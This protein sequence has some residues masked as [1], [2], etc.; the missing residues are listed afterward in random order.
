MYIKQEAIVD[1]YNTVYK[2][3]FRRNVTVQTL[4][5]MIQKILIC[6]GLLYSYRF[7]TFD[8]L[9]EDIII[10]LQLLLEL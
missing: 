5:K 6:Y 7:N 1:V 2:L 3:R 4:V 8:A 10:P 9:M